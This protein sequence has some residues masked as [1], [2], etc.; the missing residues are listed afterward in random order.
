MGK[1]I[2]V[3]WTKLREMGKITD[4]LALEIEDARTK[5]QNIINSLNECWEGIDAT[6]FTTNCNN[7]LNEFKN[8]TLYFE[9]LGQ[10]FGKGAKS[11]NSV[12]ETHSQRVKKINSMLEQEQNELNDMVGVN[13]GYH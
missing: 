8:D 1:I 11:Y 6:N 10:Y 3:N 9:M 5:Y 12:E 7:F 4:E 13:N 2:K